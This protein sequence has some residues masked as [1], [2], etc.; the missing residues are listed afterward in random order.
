MYDG[1]N[2]GCTVV[3]CLFILGKVFIANAGDSRAVLCRR[4]YDALPLS[5][6][7]TPE[8]ERTRV[9]QLVTF[10]VFIFC[11]NNAMNENLCFRL[12]RIRIC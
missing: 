10:H 12:K 11:C 2:G 6:D 9:R 4:N 1:V 3:V 5:E 7:F 8:S